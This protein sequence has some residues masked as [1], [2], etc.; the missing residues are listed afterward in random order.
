MAGVV[1]EL[2]F[3]TAV[4]M[5]L[6]LTYFILGLLPLMSETVSTD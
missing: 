3:P 5:T 4:A 1:W 6:A 2:L